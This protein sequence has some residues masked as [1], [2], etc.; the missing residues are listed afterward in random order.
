M[1]AL[2]AFACIPFGS[3]RQTIVYLQ[4]FDSLQLPCYAINWHGIVHA[5]T[6][7]MTFIRAKFQMSP[8]SNKRAVAVG[9]CHDFDS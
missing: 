4:N 6:S 9:I 2:R 3:Y 8:W 5:C 7:I 1:K